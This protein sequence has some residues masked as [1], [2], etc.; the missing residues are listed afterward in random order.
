MRH[1]ILILACGL[2][3]GLV[4]GSSYLV[5]TQ[6]EQAIA[7][8]DSAAPAHAVAQNKPPA[9]LAKQEKQ[10]DQESNVQDSQVVAASTPTVSEVP[11]AQPAASSTT[12]T[13]AVAGKTSAAASTGSRKGVDWSAPVAK[14]SAKP[15]GPVVAVPPEKVQAELRRLSS[16]DWKQRRAAI[17]SLGDW[18][19]AAA[20]AAHRLAELLADHSQPPPPPGCYWIKGP[21]TNGQMAASVLNA[22]GEPAWEPT[23]SALRAARD[24]RARGNALTAIGGLKH[25]NLVELCTPLVSDPAKEIRLQTLTV[26]R[27]S[28]NRRAAP[29]LRSFFRQTSN[30]PSERRLALEVLCNVLQKDAVPD[31][32][33]AV[34][35]REPEIRK[36]AENRLQF[37][38]DGNSVEVLTALLDHASTSRRLM[39][40]KALERLTFQERLLV[41]Q[42]APAL[43][44]RVAT[45]PDHEVR[46]AA[47]QA[48]AGLNDPRAGR[49]FLVS[50][51]QSDP[52]LKQAALQGLFNLAIDRSLPAATAVEP[53]AQVVRRDQDSAARCQALEILFR[54][55]SPQAW[56]VITQTTN[57]PDAKVQ[58]K[59]KNLQYLIQQHRRINDR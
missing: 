32:I 14:R 46:R 22:I 17:D 7:E 56:N 31:L 44:T 42:S 59:A 45:D 12:T 38:A 18:G 3:V 52:K 37:A 39:A 50:L 21:P 24:V 4:A 36:W 16:T 34:D 26:L 40:A 5:Q 43:V 28:E 57:D 6:V 47:M 11:D 15:I 13:R 33:A 29:L 20:P 55:D 35:D 53:L 27:D 30:R 54:L 8:A 25:P 51:E 41:R 2:S 58:K 19:A 49:L 10:K 9:A 1:E 48:L 23:A